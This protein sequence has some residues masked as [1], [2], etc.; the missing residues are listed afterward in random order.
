MSSM[1]IKLVCTCT[2]MFTDDSVTCNPVV[3][4][5]PH[6]VYVV[7][8]HSHHVYRRT[9]SLVIHW[10]S[11]P[12]TRCT[13]FYGT[14]TVFTDDLITCNPVVFSSPHQVYVVARHSHHVYRRTQSLVIQSCSLLHTRCTSLYGTPTMFIDVLNHPAFDKF[15]FSTMRTGEA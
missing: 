4:S 5:S 14:P 13:S 1:P 8:W 11:L 9:Q 7:V 15:D 12:Q 6:Q 2:T 10:Y 3:F